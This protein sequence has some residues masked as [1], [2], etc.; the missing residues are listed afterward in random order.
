MYT[1]LKKYFESIEK[2][3]DNINTFA[4]SQGYIICKYCSNKDYID[5]K[6]NRKR[7]YS[8]QNNYIC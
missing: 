4:Y 7:I 3:K 1:P 2:M 5:F 8:Q 6:C